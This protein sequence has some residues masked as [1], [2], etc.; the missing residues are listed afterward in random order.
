MHA[1]RFEMI[2]KK[3][4]S[5]VSLFHACRS[6]CVN[7]QYMKNPQAGI[8]YQESNITPVVEKEMP[9][10]LQA[11][12]KLYGMSL[13]LSASFAVVPLLLSALMSGSMSGSKEIF[14]EAFYAGLGLYSFLIF[15]AVSTLV[16][17][18]GFF[19]SRK[20]LIPALALGILSQIM[21]YIT[22]NNSDLEMV[23]ESAII[24]I[25]I[26]LFVPI[27][28]LALVWF[29]RQSLK[30]SY[31]KVIPLTLVFFGLMG[32]YVTSS[33]THDT[34]KSVNG[35]YFENSHIQ[36]ATYYST[37]TPDGTNSRYKKSVTDG[38]QIK[39]GIDK[40]V[41]NDDLIKEVKWAVLES[42]MISTREQCVSY[43]NQTSHDGTE[44]GRARAIALTN[45]CVFY[46]EGGR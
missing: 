15:G 5:Q 18:Y 7:I 21:G 39:P 8:D 30:G 11:V 34:V 46:L 32:S 19:R 2:Q 31:S 22:L 12:F 10:W 37:S 4:H 27:T 42:G 41:L 23:S 29:N 43:S 3:R 17:A 1:H 14:Y 25:S 24:L 44:E 36:D 26:F 6:Y 20:W 45:A 9:F 40:A 13:V 28:M 38:M 35:R 16:T 33:K